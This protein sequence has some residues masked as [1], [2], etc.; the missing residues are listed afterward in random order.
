[1]QFSCLVISIKHHFIIILSIRA[2]RFH[3]LDD[4]SAFV[5]ISL[6][7]D[8]SMRRCLFKSSFCWNNVRKLHL[9]LSHTERA[10]RG[11]GFFPSKL[12]CFIHKSIGPFG[13]DNPSCWETI[14]SLIKQCGSI[15]PGQEQQLQSAT[16]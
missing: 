14:D 1:M 10:E 16:L 6:F 4:L 2:V 9:R 15:Q 8:W 5:C 11:W 7:Q 3:L 13:C 12:S